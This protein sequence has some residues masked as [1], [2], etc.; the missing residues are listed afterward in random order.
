MEDVEPLV[1]R[2]PECGTRFRVTEAQLQMAGG[3]VR[4]GSCLTVFFG[5]DHLQWDMEQ[6]VANSDPAETLDALLKEI[7]VFEAEDVARAGEAMIPPET[8]LS[9]G[10]A[11]TE[12]GEFMEP[13]REAAPASTDLESPPDHPPPEQAPVAADNGES[14]RTEVTMSEPV[15]RNDA[16]DTVAEAVVI[17]PPP[18]PT[19]PQA[20]DRFVRLWEELPESGT[21]EP[22]SDL[23]EEAP[24]S[25]GDATAETDATG[26]TPASAGPVRTLRATGRRRGRARARPP[27]A[28]DVVGKGATEEVA[29]PPADTGPAMRVD[30]PAEEPAVARP[31]SVVRWLAAPVALVLMAAQA[32]WYFFPSW[33]KNPDMRWLPER[34][35][36]IAGCELAPLKALDQLLITDVLLRGD[37]E[38]ANLRIVN[39]LLVNTAPFDQAFPELEVAFRAPT[40]DLV[41]WKRF[42]PGDYLAPELRQRPIIPAKTPVRIE[43]AIEDPGTQSYGYE[44]SL[45]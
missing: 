19:S 17:P 20:P 1:T 12:S 39:V 5:T 36:G 10:A 6:S 9:T 14:I 3:R 25:A 28:A 13:V 18:E 30:I 38:R 24:V 32:G 40:G 42:Q 43:L 15:I 41:A 44:I 7:D 11:A 16:P 22:P 34:I 29:T 45:K 33:A 37:P 2:C 26:S 21:E 4:C 35:C 27:G 23:P 8:L 31:R